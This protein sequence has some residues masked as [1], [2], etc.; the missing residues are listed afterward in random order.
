MPD[1]Y[2]EPPVPE[3][4]PTPEDEVLFDHENRVR[5]IEGQPPLTQEDFKAKAKP[6]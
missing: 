2:V 1:P 4:E 6:G 5:A 3:P